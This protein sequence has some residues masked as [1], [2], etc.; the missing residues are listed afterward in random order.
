MGKIQYVTKG[1]TYLKCLLVKHN[2]ITAAVK[3]RCHAVTACW[4][5]MRFSV[6]KLHMQAEILSAEFCQY[7]EGN[8]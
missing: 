5:D 3:S 8:I 6:L 7:S 1:N 2:T 4:Y